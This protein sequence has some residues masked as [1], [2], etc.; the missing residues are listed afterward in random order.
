M[1]IWLGLPGCGS[2]KELRGVSVPDDFSVRIQRGAC[3]GTC[4]TYDL[5][6]QGSGRTILNGYRGLSY[7]GLY[8]KHLS[9]R[10]LRAMV[11]AI[12]EADFFAFEPRY[13]DTRI[14]DLP[15][16]TLEVVMDGQR[17]EV[18]DRYGAPET[19]EQLQTRLLELIDLETGFDPV[20]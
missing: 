4:P 10:D 19:L 9:R 12:Q 18:V 2:S 8:Q 13:D 14:S 16:F 1:L 3:F 20:Q 7:T 5:L 17:H 15:T 11:Q 6:V